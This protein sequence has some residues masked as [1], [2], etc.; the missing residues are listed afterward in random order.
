MA[1][2][3]THLELLDLI[4]KGDK[5]SVSELLEGSEDNG[6]LSERDSDGRTALDTAVI[7][8]QQ[9]IVSVLIEKGA[10]INSANSSGIIILLYRET[11]KHVV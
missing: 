1:S 5:E 2:S 7:L 11:R 8:G 10:E 4:E 9:E 6:W 3:S